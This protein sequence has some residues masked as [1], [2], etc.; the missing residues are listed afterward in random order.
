MLL[1]QIGLALATLIFLTPAFSNQ[2]PPAD[3]VRNCHNGTCSFQ[4]L[5]GWSGTIFYTDKE[6][7]FLFQKERVEGREIRCYY[8]YLEPETHK[9]MPPAL[10]LK[11]IN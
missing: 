10:M 6:K 4:S 9:L 2:C 8:S 5:V 11:S 3:K 7:P 1:R